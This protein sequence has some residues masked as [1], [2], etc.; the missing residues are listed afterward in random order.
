MDFLRDRVFPMFI[1]SKTTKQKSTSKFQYQKYKRIPSWINANKLVHKSMSPTTIPLCNRAPQSQAK[2]IGFS[3]KG[4]AQIESREYPQFYT[5]EQLT[6]YYM[7]LVCAQLLSRVRLCDPMDCSLPGF[8]VHGIFQARI[9]EW[10]AISFSRIASRPR[11][12]TCDSQ[13]Y[14]H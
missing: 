1:S 7:E 10:D 13:V 5:G 12:R 3:L 4:K 14:G 6:T 2:Q 11:D 9:L 8:S